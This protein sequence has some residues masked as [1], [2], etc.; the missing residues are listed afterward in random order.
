MDR[1]PHFSR[2]P[3]YLPGLVDRPVKLTSCLDAWG[4]ATGILQAWSEVAG[5]SWTTDQVHPDPITVKDYTGEHWGITTEYLYVRPRHVATGGRAWEVVSRGGGYHVG[6][7][8]A[9]VGPGGSTGVMILPSG[10]GMPVVTAWSLFMPLAATPILAGSIVGI[11]YDATHVRWVIVNA[12][13][14]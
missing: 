5:G 10:G 6:T 4:T 7:L 8:Q 14:S 9:D 12:M 13:C 1:V 11:S 2:P 3:I